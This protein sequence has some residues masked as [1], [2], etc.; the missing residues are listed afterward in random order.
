MSAHQARNRA[1]SRK[2]IRPFCFSRQLRW[3]I[4]KG[5]HAPCFSQRITRIGGMLR[6]SSSMRPTPR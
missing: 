2:A 4:G 1:G 6:N 5:A 3:R